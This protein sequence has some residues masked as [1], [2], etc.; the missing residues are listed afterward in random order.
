MGCGVSAQKECRLL[1][2]Q[3]RTRYFLQFGFSTLWFFHALKFSIILFPYFLYIRVEWDVAYLDKKSVD[4]SQVNT[5]Q[6][7][8]F[9]LV[10]PRTMC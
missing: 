5:E 9:N 2:G 1:T 8:F 10:S 6:G 7:I 3:Y 4:Y